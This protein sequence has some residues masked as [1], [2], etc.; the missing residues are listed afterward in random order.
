[1]GIVSSGF[2]PSQSGSL[3]QAANVLQQGPASGGQTFATFPRETSAGPVTEADV[4]GLQSVLSAGTVLSRSSDPTLQSCLYHLGDSPA[5]SRLAQ[6]GVDAVVNADLVSSSVAEA[7]SAIY[8]VSD[9]PL[10]PADVVVT[11]ETPGPTIGTALDNPTQ[12]ITGLKTDVAVVSRDTG[13]VVAVGAAP[14]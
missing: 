4:S 11:I 6:A 12:S 9:D 1:M 3:A 10:S 8:L 13:A 14:W 2:Q 5:A 7:D